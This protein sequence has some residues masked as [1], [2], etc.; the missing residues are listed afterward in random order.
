MA[1]IE[2]ASKGLNEITDKD[3]TKPKVIHA[4]ETINKH[5]SSKW[6]ERIDWRVVGEYAVSIVPTVLPVIV[7]AFSQSRKR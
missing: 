6:Y 1:Q 4:T 5:Q 7:C 3:E 2:E